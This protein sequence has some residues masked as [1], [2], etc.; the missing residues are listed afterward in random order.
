[1]R[2]V[3]EQILDYELRLLDH[4]VIDQPAIAEYST[5]VP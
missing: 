1:M 5:I 3:G 2:M 4:G